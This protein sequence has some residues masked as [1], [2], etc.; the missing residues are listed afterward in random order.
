MYHGSLTLL[1][2]STALIRDNMSN[3][4]GQTAG[5]IVMC[6]GNEILVIDDKDSKG[7]EYDMDLD[8]LVF[9]EAVLILND[10]G[11]SGIYPKKLKQAVLGRLRAPT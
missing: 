10:S 8:V 5:D 11:K 4:P 6:S 2:D 7:V 1:R 3:M 9:T